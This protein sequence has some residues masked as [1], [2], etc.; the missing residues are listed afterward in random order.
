M[1]WLMITFALLVL[2]IGVWIGLGAPGWPYKPTPG[3]SLRR[4]AEK[5]PINPIAWA[6]P[7]ESER[8]ER[9]RRRR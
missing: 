5:R 9:S 8:R 1:S 6:R 3:G 4:R 7:R 2:A